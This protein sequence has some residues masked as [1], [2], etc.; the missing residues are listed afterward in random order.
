MS[1]GVPGLDGQ[2]LLSIAV[3]RKC[4]DDDEQFGPAAS[5]HHST[6]PP[7]TLPRYSES[8]VTASSVAEPPLN[9]AKRRYDVAPF[10][11]SQSNSTGEATFAA[12]LAGLTSCGA[13][14]FDVAMATVNEERADATPGQAVP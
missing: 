7:G 1:A 10:T 3:K 13:T 14:Q 6:L 11:S 2:P 12:L 4:D 5:T 8:V 9:A